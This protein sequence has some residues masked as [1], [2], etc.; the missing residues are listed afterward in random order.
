MKTYLLDF[1][2]KIQKYSQKL[3]D[4]TL[5]TNQH[6][7][8]MGSIGMDK[9]IYIFRLNNELLVSTDGHVSK[10]KWEYL[11]NNSILV[12]LQDKSYLFK[13][14][15]FDKNILALKTDN[16]NN[17]TVF[18]NENQFDGELNNIE[19][20]KEFLEDK[21]LQNNLSQNMLN[22]EQKPIYLDTNKKVNE[23]SKNILKGLFRFIGI[24]LTMFSILIIITYLNTKQD[25]IRFHIFN[26]TSMCFCGPDITQADP[27]G[28]L[29]VLTVLGIAGVV[30][31]IKNSK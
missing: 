16:N 22:E 21:Y 24:A 10:G 15:F 23:S 30:L 12:D 14:G 8:L 6:W 27:I 19:K 11:G 26:D 25:Q 20:L 28:D 31:F 2:P 9:T 29:S 3:D 4:I 7:V 17:Y 1:L 18:V 13:H 5:L